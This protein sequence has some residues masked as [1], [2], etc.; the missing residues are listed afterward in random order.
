MV[1]IHIIFL[2][3]GLHHISNRLTVTLYGCSIV[4]FKNIHTN[5][6]VY[7]CSLVFLKNIHIKSIGL[8]AVQFSTKL[9]NLTSQW[10]NFLEY[11]LY[12]FRNLLFDLLA[13]FL[14]VS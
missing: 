8:P 13:Y 5:S 3:L 11:I 14:L 4:Y 12:T 2:R 10:K 6:Y 9:F 1:N 7:G